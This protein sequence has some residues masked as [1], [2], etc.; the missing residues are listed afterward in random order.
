[1]IYYLSAFACLLSL[2]LGMAVGAYLTTLLAVGAIR[3]AEARSES[4]VIIIKP[5]NPTIK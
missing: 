2:L 1:M 5:H 3:R 4:E